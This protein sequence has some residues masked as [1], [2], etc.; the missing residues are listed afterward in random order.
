M[1]KLFLSAAAFLVLAACVHR[2][3]YRDLVGN[4]G[5]EN[6]VNLRLLDAATN[7]PLANV[8]IRVAGGNDKIAVTTDENG[9][10]K[11]PVKKSLMDPYTVV[12]VMRPAGVERYTIE[13]V[14]SPPP[15]TEVPPPAQIS[16]EQYDAQLADAGV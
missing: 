8:P 9:H 5:A 11:L 10:F 2:P 1:R 16:V 3:Y 13:R 15:R 14:S 6:E 7:K 12:E 4:A